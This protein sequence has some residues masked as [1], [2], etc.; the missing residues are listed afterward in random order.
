MT[1]DEIK[2]KL[3]ICE[4][5]LTLIKTGSKT[6]SKRTGTKQK[7]QE[8]NLLKEGLK[9]KL[10]EVDGGT[11]TTDDEAKAEKLAS[12]GIDVN[13]T[14]EATGVEFGQ[15]ETGFIAK[16]TGK[17]LAKSL[18]DIGDQLG[19]MKAIRIQ[20][21][22]FDIAV[23][24][25]G[26]AAGEDEFSFDIEN[27]KLIIS[28]FT[29]SKVLVDVGVKG[30]GEP[31]INVDVLANE[32][33]KHFKSLNEED[34]EEAPYGRQYIEVSIRDA[35][36][37]LDILDDTLNKSQFEMN[38]SNVYYFAKPSTAY[39]ALMDFRAHDVEILDTNADDEEEDLEDF[40]PDQPYNENMKKL[41][42]SSFYE[43]DSAKIDAVLKAAADHQ[44]FSIDQLKKEL[45]QALTQR[46]GEKSSTV[47]AILKQLYKFTEP[48]III[49][50]LEGHNSDSLA[51]EGILGRNAVPN[52][53][54]PNWYKDTFA[55]ANK[56]QLK[57]ID[58]LIKKSS[59]QHVAKMASRGKY[60][61][62]Q[63]QKVLDKR[64]GSYTPDEKVEEGRGDG[65]TIFQ[66]I[67]DRAAE[68]GVSTKEAAMEVLE[69]IGE[70]FEVNF[71]FGR[72]GDTLEE[73]KENVNPELDRLVNG[74]VRKLADRYDY[75]L[76]DA[77]FAVMGV[78]RKQNYDGLS[79]ELKE[80]TSTDA[81]AFAYSRSGVA[82]IQKAYDVVISVMK[83][84]AKKYKEGD[85]SVIPD[86][87]ALT[88][89][90]KY[91][92]DLLDAKVS[93][94]G[95][96]QE[97][98]DEE[99]TT[100]GD[101]ETRLKNHPESAKIKAIQNLVKKQKQQ[102]KKEGY[103]G[104]SEIETIVGAIGYDDIDHF[105]EDNPGAVDAI[106]QMIGSVPE[107]N[108]KLGVEFSTSELADMGFYDI[109]GYDKE[110]GVEK[111]KTRNRNTSKERPYGHTGQNED[112][113]QDKATAS[114]EK[115][116][117]GNL[118]EEK[119][120]CDKCKGKGCSHCKDLGYHYKK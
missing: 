19:S 31:I 79:E 37:A 106:I 111:T 49:R 44:G 90:K 94:T 58:D 63:I 23:I 33:T 60:F 4:K 47:E 92:E 91:L 39:D 87:K 53:R 88:K 28:D 57:V 7:I 56:E 68:D 27:D 102:I 24:Y 93:G 10:L 36:K 50:H 5:A 48:K 34:I 114:L 3:S 96:D 72:I 40:R 77:V 76:Q 73:L 118:K 59:P 66:I 112:A 100:K 61:Q 17:A 110:E 43:S 109:E 115:Y 120:E 14:A 45:H 46:E 18:K 38:G 99:D 11:V 54:D 85:K 51:A 89:K 8:L 74:F 29:F 69:A 82:K 105:F 32:F 21:N 70:E 25:K 108:R 103:Y 16:A 41:R 97:V 107:F 35:R 15:N 113:T 117:K 80:D 62:D 9:K 86:L 22:S 78:L 104:T 13:L 6:G 65:A 75:T 83:D 12:K 95:K 98:V 101:Y 55:W 1:Y 71:E 20:P 67:R 52:W 84:L 119:V 26:E 116:K 30:S 2:T 42:E 81:N 64:G